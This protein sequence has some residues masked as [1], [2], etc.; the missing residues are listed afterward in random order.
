MP[1]LID[2]IEE[3][4]G[5]KG[6]E[7]GISNLNEF[8]DDDLAMYPAIE[9]REQDLTAD[10]CEI[11]A[12]NI[13]QEI[14][15]APDEDSMI[16]PAR[17][18]VALAFNALMDP[19]RISNESDEKPLFQKDEFKRVSES[20]LRTCDVSDI[21]LRE[22]IHESKFVEPENS[23]ELRL[24]LLKLIH[25]HASDFRRKA[26]IGAWAYYYLRLMGHFGEEVW[27]R[28][29]AEYFYR[30]FLELYGF[31]SAYRFPSFSVRGYK[32]LEK[33]YIFNMPGEILY[34]LY[35]SIIL[36]ENREFDYRGTK[37]P[38]EQLV[39]EYPRGLYEGRLWLWNWCKRAAGKKNLDL[40]VEK[41]L[42]ELEWALGELDRSDDRFIKYTNSS[43]SRIAYLR[44]F[45]RRYIRYSLENSKR[46]SKYFMYARLVNPCYFSCLRLKANRELVSALIHIIEARQNHRISQRPKRPPWKR[47]GDELGAKILD[48]NLERLT[49]APV[50]PNSRPNFTNQFGGR[51][52]CNRD[53]NWR[54]T[55]KS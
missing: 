13:K 26:S 27:S 14:D 35:R 36:V 20:W 45:H 15:A 39:F 2:E 6:L 32:L 8:Q 17:A 43:R 18:L 55:Q 53:G 34:L 4:L 28:A 47:L 22:Y 42:D 24:S 49:K 46:R 10:E 12:N 31:A 7:E 50:R 9:I 40:P 41:V 19:Q 52:I 11:I 3:I 16:K 30:T 37:N 33:K 44:E 25:T 54:A 51:R 5:D 23:D 38:L 48:R 21:D 29:G 1:S